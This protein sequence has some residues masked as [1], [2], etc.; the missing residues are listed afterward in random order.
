MAGIYQ[1]KIR[2]D[3]ISRLYHAAKARGIH[4]TTLINQLLETALDTCEQGDG[5]VSD[6]AADYQAR[7]NPEGKGR[8]KT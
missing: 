5:V 6:L 3:L 8:K 4:M 2:D 7:P 1:P